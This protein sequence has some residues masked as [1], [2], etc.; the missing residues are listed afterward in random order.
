MLFPAKRPLK[1]GVCLGVMMALNTN[2]A[3]ADKANFGT[4]TLSANFQPSA[5][6]I[7]G[8][9]GGAFSL[10]AIANRDRS[11]NLCLG[12]AEQNPDF[13]IILQKDFSRLNIQV[14]SFGKDTT[15]MIKGPDGVIRCG[16]D[17]KGSKDAS[18]VDTGWKA[19]TYQIWVGAVEPGLKWNYTLSVHE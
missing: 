11:G 16:D 10:P 3:W 15:L 2:P 9:T 8:Y 19:G 1:Y 18:I 14:N 12:F 4:L 7:S 6:V 13:T 17:S 5:G